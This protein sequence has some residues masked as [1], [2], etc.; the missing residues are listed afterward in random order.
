[1]K[2]LYQNKSICEGFV[3]ESEAKH[4]FKNMKNGHTP[5]SDGFPADFFK[6]FWNDLGKYLLDS[7]NCAFIKG[8]LSVTQKLGVLTCFPK[9]DKPRE[10]MKNLR[11]ITLLNVDCKILSG[12][13]AMRMQNVLSDIISDTQKGFLK[14]RY[15]GENIQLVYDVMSKLKKLGK[16]GL[17]ILIDFEKAFD[18]LEWGY[19]F[20]VL[21]V[22][23]F[24]KDFI[25]W[26]KL[27]YNDPCSCV[28]NS[29]FF[30]QQFLP[31]RGCRQGDRLSPYLF[32]LAIEPLV[33]D[34]ISHNN[35]KGI[36]IENDQCKIRQYADDIFLLLE[37]GDNSLQESLNTFQEFC[38]CSGL[39]MNME[40]TQMAWIGLSRTVRFVLSGTIQAAWNKF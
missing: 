23:N 34:I 4:V 5:G 20:K 9:G 17:I 36:K 25:T 16:R 28:I 29:G 40:K 19:I 39:K 1:M 11:P 18:S 14:G 22:R 35:I 33:M 8:E 10:F 12:I 15:I 7:L 24:G 32:I 27:L 30:S 6:F 3:S 31:E 37:E 2:V 38:H 13:L 26:I 21:R